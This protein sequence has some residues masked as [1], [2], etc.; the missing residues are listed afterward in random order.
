MKPTTNCVTHPKHVVHPSL[1]ESCT[2]LMNAIQFLGD[3]L[4]SLDSRL[5]FYQVGEVAASP[6]PSEARPIVTSDKSPMK[7]F[8]EDTEHRVRMLAHNVKDLSDRLDV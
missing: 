2:D 7:T 4:S 6:S 1:P 8:L 3:A 5:Q